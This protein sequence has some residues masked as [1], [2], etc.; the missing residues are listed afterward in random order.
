MK[1]KNLKTS[2]KEAYMNLLLSLFQ[3]HLANKNAPKLTQLGLDIKDIEKLDDHHNTSSIPANNTSHVVDL[4]TDSEEKVS[5]NVTLN[6]NNYISEIEGKV[7]DFSESPPQKVRKNAAEKT[8]THIHGMT[9]VSKFTSVSK[10]SSLGLI[11]LD[12]LTKVNKKLNSVANTSLPNIERQFSTNTEPIC[13]NLEHENESGLNNHLSKDKRVDDSNARGAVCHRDTAASEQNL[14]SEEYTKS[15]TQD[16][17]SNK[18]CSMYDRMMEEMSRKQGCS[19]DAGNGY[20]YVLDDTSE[21]TEIGDSVCGITDSL[22]GNNIRDD[23]ETTFCHGVQLKQKS[24]K[25]CSSELSSQ[26]NKC[27][28]V[29]SEVVDELSQTNCVARYIAD[30]ETSVYTKVTCIENDKTVTLANVHG[31][32]SK[33]IGIGANSEPAVK[34][35]ATVNRSSHTGPDPES[36]GRARK[37][38]SFVP[39]RIFVPDFM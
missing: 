16:V 17:M 30:E 11:P 28:A 12:R 37:R 13:A 38:K 2:F 14:V 29:A 19:T 26:R 4:T 8:Q 22:E 36:S 34:E 6:F 5:D 31:A 27:N 21:A 7:G 23:G 25:S 33:A 20:N 24:M 9:G 10:T 32:A 3:I 35:K 15:L 39:Q 1:I 18:Y